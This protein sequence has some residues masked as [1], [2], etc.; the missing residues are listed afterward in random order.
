MCESKANKKKMK[1]N[2]RKAS[3]LEVEVTPNQNL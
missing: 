1:L 2:V 3:D